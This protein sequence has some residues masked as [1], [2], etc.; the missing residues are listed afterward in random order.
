MLVT[1]GVSS[2]GLPP[3]SRHHSLPSVGLFFR[4]SGRLP[5][6]FHRRLARLVPSLRLRRSGRLMGLCGHR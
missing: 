4:E 2:F 1:E 3:I 6:P 5:T